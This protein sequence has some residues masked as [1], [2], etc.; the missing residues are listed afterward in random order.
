M[1]QITAEDVKKAIYGFLEEQYLSRTDKEQKQLAKAQ[2]EANYEKVAQLNEALTIAK[3]KYSFEEWIEDAATRM[4]KQLHFGTHISKGI[5]PDSKGDNLVFYKNNA[6]NLVDSSSIKSKLLDANGNAAALPLAAFFEYLVDEE[7]SITIGEAIVADIKNI[8]EVFSTNS[9]KSKEYFQSFYKAL[10]SNVSTPVTHERN[11][12]LLWPKNKPNSYIALV[13]LYPSVFTHEF[14]KKLNDLRFSEANKTARADRFKKT[15]PNTA[16]VSI[17]SIAVTKLGGTKPQNISLLTSRQGGRNYLLPSLP[18]QFKQS[19]QFKI[20]P[21][22]ES[23]FSR[24]LEYRCRDVL[25]ALY[26]L[27][28]TNYNNVDIRNARKDIL[29]SLLYKVLAVAA[30]I[31]EDYPASWSKDYSLNINEKFWLDPQRANQ[32][33]AFA[34]Q[35]QT[36]A[37]QDEISQRFANWVNYLLRK[38]LKA[39]KHEIADAEHLE[40]QQEMQ[41]LIKQTQRQGMEIFQ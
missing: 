21:S 26:R 31:Q 9:E 22:A 19:Q 40:W 13:P 3:Q 39:A 16:Y 14:Y 11:K 27:I 34:E 5:H 35:K 36:T 41:E 18:P 10:K 30:S 28:K 15:A 2:E 12:Q 32:D 37:W 1:Q 17:N 20:Y 23:I 33:E 29:D 24:N 25:Q 7:K 4:A 8:E 38:E 6:S